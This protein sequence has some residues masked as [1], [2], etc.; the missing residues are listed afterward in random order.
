MAKC[1]FCSRQI[2]QGKGVIFV[3]FAR[4]YNFCQLSPTVYGHPKISS[5]LLLS[6]ILEKGLDNQ[7]LPPAADSVTPVLHY[8]IRGK[9]YYQRQSTGN[10]QAE[11]G[12][13]HA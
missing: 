13:G 9:D 4:V 6:T 12:A 10:A 2:E 11:K 3:A 1:S 5:A 8:N 7:P